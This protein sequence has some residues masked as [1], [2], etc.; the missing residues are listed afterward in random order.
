MVTFFEAVGVGASGV[1]A[2]WSA[3]HDATTMVG[4][5]TLWV[6]SPRDARAMQRAPIGMAAL[7]PR[8]S[9]SGLGGNL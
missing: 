5:E 7:T 1:G 3:A 8:P 9:L 4:E 2:A 6:P